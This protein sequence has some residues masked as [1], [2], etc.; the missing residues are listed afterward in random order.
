MNKER[1]SMATESIMSNVVITDPRD[2]EMFVNVM[3][4]AMK[5][6]ETPLPCRIKSS[7]YTPD[8]MREALGKILSKRKTRGSHELPWFFLWIINL[9]SVC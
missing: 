9:L 2:A 3:E 4:Q 8:E 1:D 6:A 5:V 7:D